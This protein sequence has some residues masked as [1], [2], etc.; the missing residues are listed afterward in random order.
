MYW[1]GNIHERSEYRMTK[2]R[3]LD[4]RSVWFEGP[5]V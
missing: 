2:R 3:V 4:T 5:K 1:E